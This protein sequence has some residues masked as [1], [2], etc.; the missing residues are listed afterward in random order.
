MRP[1]LKILCLLALALTA[2]A[3]EYKLYVAMLDQTPVVLAD[4]T[5]WMMDKGDMFPVLMYKEMQTKV[6]LQ[7]DSTQFRVD[8]SKVRKLTAGEVEASRPNY[9]RNVE[10]YRKSK[11]KQ[12]LSDPALPVR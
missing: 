1:L 12:S 11:L 5:Q 7:L 8:A 10:N 2:Q 4:G 9:L 3:K 6:V